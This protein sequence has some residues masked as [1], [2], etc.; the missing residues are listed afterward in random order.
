M[1]LRHFLSITFVF[2]SAVLTP[3][4]AQLGF[5]LEIKKPEPYENRVLKAE[6]TPDKKIKFTKR[7]FQNLTTRYNYFY[8]ANNKLNDVILMAKNATKDDYGKL[9][10]FYNYS[11]DATAANEQ[12]LDSVIYKAKTGIVLHD[13]RSDWADNMYMLWGA[14]YFFQKEFDSAALMFQFINYA[15]ADKEKD[16]YYKYIGSRMDGNSA[17]SIAT[18]EDNSLAK[19]AFSTSPSRNDAFVWQIRTLIEAGRM[20]DAGILISTLKAD[21]VFPERLNDDLEEVQAYWFYK[22]Q[23]WDSAATHLINALPVAQSGQEKA[24]WEYLAAQMWELEKKP[25]LAHDLYA[26]AISHGTDPVMDVYARLNLLRT[27]TS[28]EENYIDQNIADL[29]K[30]ARR[31]KYADYRDIIYY[32]AAQMEISRG[33]LAAA[34]EY[35]LKAAKYNNGNLAGSNAFLQIAD[36]SY[37]QKKYQQAAAFYDSV[38][39]DNLNEEE[40]KRVEHRRT[41]LAKIVMN[42]LLV[43]RQDSL[44]KIAALPEEERKDFINK[45]VKKLRKEQGLADESNTV[46]AGSANPFNAPAPEDL[47]AK[48]NKGEWYFYNSSLRTAGAAQFKQVWG[49]RPNADNWRRF[50]QVSNQLLAKAPGNT[51]PDAATPAVV[52]ES[53]NELSYE[54]FLEKLPL[55]DAALQV[56]NDSI[57]NALF[58]L[59][60]DYLNILEDYASSIEAFEKL[61]SRSPAHPRTDEI[62]F[63]LYYAYLKSGNA[64]KAG[65]MKALLAK[66]HSASR[67]SEIVTTGKDPAAK[68]EAS[69]AATKDYEAIY[70]MYIEGRFT[71]AEAAKRRADSLYQTNYWQPQ[72]LYI[73]AVYQVKQRSDS[74]AIQTLQTLIAQNN[75][76]PI[77]AKAQNLIDVVRRRTQIEA[78]LN[79]LQIER[80]KDA[81][82]TTTQ[83]A[84]KP[85]EESEAT[86]MKRDTSAISKPTVKPVVIAKPKATTDT[87]STKTIAV[88]K[89][90]NTTYQFEPDLKHYAVI[91]LNKVDPVF[92][93]ETKNAFARFNRERYSSVPL[94]ANVIEL[95]SVHK[96]VLIGDFINAQTA[97]DYIKQASRFAPTEIVPWLKRDKYSFTIISPNNLEI[98]QELKNLEQYEKF[99]QQSLPK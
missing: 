12:E 31:E 62:L 93:G 23:M 28:N 66:N 92:S 91:I 90:R 4:Y 11:L 87:L 9:L 39:M 53:G 97:L 33:N 60:T 56:S 19:K 14:A 47:F 71:D 30:M 29:V 40:V 64:T 51:R 25:E 7:F 70:D 82:V 73:E 48:Q 32:M 88:Q 13:L 43:N 20:N 80:P 79:D 37:Q 55:T 77:A 85:V 68:V 34:Q 5:D 69:P 6:K 3:S 50:S 36:L 84:P 75:E 86:A 74:A 8:N 67:W 57:N 76:S 2:L 52:P 72:L 89:K 81:V 45:L 83:P 24:R 1:K 21:P 61:L 15:F 44:Q 27:S 22:Q 17:L 95:D 78:E 96:F 18:K 99:L 26:K 59:G 94:T 42:E 63:N 58:A 65:E 98:L 35:L 49:N 46:T 41:D 38:R 16:G 10:P 54:A